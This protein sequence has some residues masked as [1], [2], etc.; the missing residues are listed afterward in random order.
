MNQLTQPHNQQFLSEISANLYRG[1]FSL[2]EMLSNLHTERGSMENAQ[3]LAELNNDDALMEQL[4]DKI[5]AL[6]EKITEI[7][8]LIDA[9]ENAWQQVEERIQ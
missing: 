4:N 3:E 6:D 1:L 7:E 2:K 5:D 9:V 8:S